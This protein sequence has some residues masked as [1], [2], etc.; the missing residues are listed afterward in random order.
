MLSSRPT[1]KNP[2]KRE[3]EASGEIPT[4]CPS[5][6]PIRGILSV[7]YARS[8]VPIQELLGA[9]FPGTIPGQNSLN[10][11]RRGNMAGISP[12]LL[13]FPLRGTLVVGRDD[14]SLER[15][16]VFDHI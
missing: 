9:R 15:V 13:G 16:K 2:A 5:A 4:E 11:H 8:A 1:P 3:P 14:I 10:P 7:L 6:I 12:L